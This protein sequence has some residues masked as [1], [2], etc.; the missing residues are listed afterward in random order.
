MKNNTPKKTKLVYGVGIN[1][2]DYA[3]CPTV[4]GRQVM[5]PFYRAW[6]NMLRRCYSKAFH[7]ARPTYAGCTV[8]SE[9]LIFSKFKLWMNKQEWQAKQL[10]KDILFQNNR[11]Y[12]PLACVFVSAEIN[13]L[14]NEYSNGRGIN[15]RGVS[16]FVNGRYQAQCG[17]YGKN[18]HIGYYGTQEEASEAYKKFK[19]KHISE[20]AN[21]QSEPLRTALLNY[22]IEG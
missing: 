20:V 10:D 11:V 17:A 19:Y 2:A 15:P 6:A 18:R 12:G 7:K 16:L 8:T 22:V 1:D 9:W 5:C 13:T 3:I 21:Q 14:L 4:N